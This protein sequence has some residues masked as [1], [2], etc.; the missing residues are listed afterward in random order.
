MDI[1][2]CL[3]IW[4]LLYH[5]F[6]DKHKG[7]T[8]PWRAG[9]PDKNQKKGTIGELNVIRELLYIFPKSQ[10]FSNVYVTTESGTTEIDIVVLDKT[11]LYVIESK[12]YSGFITGNIRSKTWKYIHFN[13]SPYHFYNP[14]WQNNAHIKSLQQNLNL[15][16]SDF[17]S[18]IVFGEKSKLGT[19]YGNTET[20]ITHINDLRTSIRS[21]KDSR[22]EVFTDSQMN[23][24]EKHL[25]SSTNVSYEVKA[26][27][28][29]SVR[30][31]REANQ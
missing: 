20:A 23:E 31:K 24:I 15:K 26:A 7:A 30:E 10:V 17:V 16:K 22:K 6:K 18:Y 13:K 29:H 8:P 25:I 9:P 21:K 27:H 11:G 2:I 1:L 19:I 12:N 3:L 5:I 4:F 14:I 28:I